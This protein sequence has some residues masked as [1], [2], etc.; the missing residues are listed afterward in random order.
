[1]NEKKVLLIIFTVAFFLRFGALSY[2]PRQHRTPSADAQEYDELALNLLA[3]K[4]FINFNTGKPTAWRVPLYPI[5]LASIYSV[6]G[7]NY[8]AVRIVQCLLGAFLCVLIYLIAKEIF[9]SRVALI[10]SLTLCFYKPYILYS[11]FGGPGFLFSENLFTFL[12]A[13]FVYFIT[14]SFLPKPGVS[15]SIIAGFLLGLM[16]LTRPVASLLP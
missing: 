8:T 6:F 9:S 7:H 12:L 10:A 13:V 2:L 1:M 3:G 14:R 4:G 15:N 5:F 16:A 11:Y